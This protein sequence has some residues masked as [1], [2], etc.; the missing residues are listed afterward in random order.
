MC[1]RFVVAGLLLAAPVRAAATDLG[2]VVIKGERPTFRAGE[3]VTL[4]WTSLPPETEEFELL[5]SLDGGRQFIRLTEMQEPDL[6]SLEWRVPNL[7][8]SDAHLRLRVG[9]NGEEID[10]RTERPFHDP[11]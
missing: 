8:S 10:L 7:P 6:E 5:L 1:S 9:L 11:E 2:R 3:V 4:R